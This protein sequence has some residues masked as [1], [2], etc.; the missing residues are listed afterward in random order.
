MFARENLRAVIF[1]C[2]GVIADTEA[3]WDASQ[4]ELFRRRGLVYDRAAVKPCLVGLSL[5]AGAAWLIE[6]FDWP[7]DAANL[8]AERRDLMRTSLSRDASFMPGAQNCLQWM[9]SQGLQYALATALDGDLFAALDRR[10]GLRELFAHRVFLLEGSGA[11]SK[12][13][14]ALFLQVARSCA[15]PAAECAVAE[16][17]PGGLRGARAAGMRAIGFTTTFAASDLSAADV[18]VPDFR[19]FQELLRSGE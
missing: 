9:Q 11:H 16:D 4:A 19:A 5:E 14:G 6:N 10:L 3:L 12:E 8:A 17:A 2:E 1:D 7:G 18:I 15:W 13:D